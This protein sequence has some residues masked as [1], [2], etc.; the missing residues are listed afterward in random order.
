MRRSRLRTLAATCP[1]CLIEAIVGL[2]RLIAS[3][4]AALRGVEEL[5]SMGDA[6]SG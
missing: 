6:G 3:D 2:A 4:G 5:L 1:F